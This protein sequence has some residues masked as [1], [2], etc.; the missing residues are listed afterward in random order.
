MTGFRS[1]EEAGDQLRDQAASCRRLASKARTVEGCDAL[2]TVARQF[3]AD[4][5]RIDPRELIRPATRCDLDSSV[6][7]RL[8]L[9][10]QAALAFPI[11]AVAGET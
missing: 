11:G 2:Q 8:A 3:D 6:R 1:R 4:A 10:R 5:Q 7:V 9:R